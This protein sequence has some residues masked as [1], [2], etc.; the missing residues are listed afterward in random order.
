MHT[1]IVIPCFNEA[2]RLPASTLR[3]YLRL[4]ANVGFVMVNDGSRDETLAVLH[5]LQDAFPERVDVIDLPQNRGKA[6]AVRVGMLQAVQEETVLVGYW[7]ADLATPLAA[8]DDFAQV[9][10]AKPEVDIVMG[11]RVAFL[12]RDIHRRA[13]R[14][15]LGRVFATAA[16]LAL[17]LVVYDTQCGAKL[18]R[19]TPTTAALF[20][21]PFRSRWIFDVELLARYLNSGGKV[22]G[23]YE[24]PLHCWRD[25][26]AS[27]VV[28]RDYLRAIFELFAI[29]LTYGRVRRLRS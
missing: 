1:R 16:S 4:Q 26:G 23:L 29:Y 15:Y 18:M 5:E 6:E 27:K 8:I 21:Q 24:F 11:A 22:Q 20:A 12:G 13:L 3:E 14:H 2:Q 17:G 25:I 19:V 28:A 9:L 7:D 10:R